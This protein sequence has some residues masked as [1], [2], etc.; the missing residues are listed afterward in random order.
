MLASSYKVES[1][2]KLNEQQLK[3]FL[4]ILRDKSKEAGVFQPKKQYAFQ[5]YKYNNLKGRDKE[6]AEPSQLRMIEAMWFEISNQTTDE[7]RSQAL[8]KFLKRIVKVDDMAFLEKRDVE[9]IVRALKQMKRQKE[10]KQL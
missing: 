5:K 2:T 10:E 9:K 7:T 8:R 3:Q 6:M 4:K 1:C